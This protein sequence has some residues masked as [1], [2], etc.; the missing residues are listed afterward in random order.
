MSLGL[1]YPSE[2]QLTAASAWSRFGTPVATHLC[3]SVLG[4]STDTT[5]LVNYIVQR[6]EFE[7][8]LRTW[9][10]GNQIV[11]PTFFFWR[12]GSTKQ[13]SI[14]GLLR[15]IIHQIICKDGNIASHIPDGLHGQG[16]WTDKR[17]FLTLESILQNLPRDRYVCLVIDGLDEFEGNADSR[18]LLI[19][20]VKKI[21]QHR[22][23]K[24]CVSSRPETMFQNAFG[25]CHG[26]R[27]QDLT[28]HDIKLYIRGKLFA[29][30]RMQNFQKE[31]PW[32]TKR[33]VDK[34]QYKFVLMESSS[35]YT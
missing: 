10:A 18:K 28:K 33:L 21:A 4:P 14:N 31:K 8:C 30:K 13:K 11:I 6:E 15:S 1:A 3:F 26:L 35:G 34:I 22:S 20:L 29:H 25:S 16:V 24:V 5:Q 7:T 2:R 27:L 12:A 19:D 17:L 32:D 23:F 9:S